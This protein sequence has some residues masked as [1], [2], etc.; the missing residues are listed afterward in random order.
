MAKWQKPD[1][2]IFVEEIPHTA[3]GKISKLELRKLVANLDYK[4]P[5]LR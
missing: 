3:T 2:V 1:D 4:H 5:D